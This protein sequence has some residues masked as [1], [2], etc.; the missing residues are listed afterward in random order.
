MDKELIKT[1][2]Y[3][4]KA[5][6]IHGNK[7]DYSI[8]KYEDSHSIIEY[9]CPE[10]GI[11]KQNAGLHIK[12]NSRG[13]PKCSIMERAIKQRLT[14]EIFIEHSIEKHG[15]KYDY[16]KVVYINNHTVV[17]IF[18]KKCD[19]YFEQIPSRHMNGAG[20]NDCAIKKNSD[21]SRSDRDTFIKN[22]QSIHGNHYDYSKVIYISAATKVI[23]IC[24]THGEFLQTPNKHFNHSQGC[25]DC[26]IIKNSNNL[27]KTT[28]EFINEAKQIYG[29]LYDYSNVNYI[30]CNE[31]VNIK[32]NLHNIYFE[33]TPSCH[34]SNKTGCT[35]CISSKISERFLI[36]IDEFI[37]RA[38]EF[39]KYK[40]DYSGLIYRTL[41]DNI[42]IKCIQHNIYFNQRADDHL[43]YI[44][45]PKCQLCPSCELW[46]T[47]GKLCSYCIPTCHNKK[48]QK[49][50]EYA[51][52]D[53]LR[54]QLP[55]NEFIH[56]K[57]VGTDCTEG[58]LFPDIRFDC[59]YY[60]LIIEVDEHKHRGADYKC[61][62]Q[63]MYDIIAKLGM[64]CVFIR[65]NPD[66]K[67]SD[68]NILLEKVKEYLEL[69]ED[70]EIW[71]EFG[72]YTEYL[73]Y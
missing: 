19:K 11:I 45:C 1:N 64:P 61:D 12:K 69:S 32:C 5:I 59:D 23:I 6:K 8:T 63:R 7:Y 60:Q 26:A 4:E 24:P 42:T 35:K 14:K 72:L 58:H 39:H 62:E 15:N 30:S 17:L 66:S 16:S 53:F 49:T 29:E 3:I 55:D 34:L 33:Q 37:R 67:Q 73:F 31:Y 28:E 48:Y 56:N 46:K 54:E 20:C 41:N 38:N 2:K 50:K 9:I 21:N 43:K 44:A 36:G 47:F 27:R 52:V 71:N 51:V 70:N 68:K 13:C 57:S 25:N 22:A 10:H 65:Y 40:Y 18:C